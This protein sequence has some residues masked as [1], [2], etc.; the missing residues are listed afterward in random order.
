MRWVINEIIFGWTIPLSPGT[1]EFQVVKGNSRFI[2]PSE[3]HNDG[4][5]V[6]WSNVYIYIY[7]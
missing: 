4:H 7:I 6:F 1:N 5:Y 2:L 3:I